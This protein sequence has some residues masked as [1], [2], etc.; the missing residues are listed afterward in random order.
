MLRYFSLVISVVF[1]PLLMPSMVYGVILFVVPQSTSIPPQFKS[2]LYLMIILATLVIP[3]VAIIGLRLSGSVKSLHMREIKDRLIPF[4]VT[5]LFYGLVVYF[6]SLK[7]EFDPIFWQILALITCVIS[8]L[9]MV[10]IFWKMSAHMTGIGGVFALLVIL[11]I[12]F[13]SFLALYPLLFCLGLVGVIGSARLY[14][15]AHKPMEIYG[16]FLFGLVTCLIGFN[17]IWS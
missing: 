6:I 9:T 11:G 5:S 16:G 17:L 3:M 8:G 10:T 13:P 7:S 1:Q 4:S 15:N 12:K 14:L 2:S